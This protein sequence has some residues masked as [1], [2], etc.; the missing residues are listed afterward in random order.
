MQINVLRSSNYILFDPWF[1]RPSCSTYSVTS[2]YL[3]VH[4]MY[5]VFSYI[6]PLICT[7]STLSLS[8]PFAKYLKC[9]KHSRRYNAYSCNQH[10]KYIN[11]CCLAQLVEHGKKEVERRTFVLQ[12]GTSMLILQES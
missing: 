9:S 12:F 8:S 10:T 11:E 2:C 6:L 3:Y 7:F 5:V 1:D 4:L